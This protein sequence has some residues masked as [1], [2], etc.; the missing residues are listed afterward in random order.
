MKF[1][2]D[3]SMASVESIDDPDNMGILT[4]TIDKLGQETHPVYYTS[5]FATNSEGGFVAIPKVG[6]RI[7]TCSPYGTTDWYYLGSTFSPEPDEAV[8]DKVLDGYISPYERANPDATRARG[9]SQQSIIKGERGGGLKISEQYN[10]EMFNM[11]TRLE[12]T[13]GKKV[14]IND[15]PQTDAI[16]IGTEN[17]SSIKVFDN[18]QNPVNAPRSVEITT[19]GPQKYI[20]Q[21]D[22][23]DIVVYKGG[24]DL[25]LL[26]C[27]NASGWG[28]PVSTGNVNIQSKQKDINIF[29]K[30]GAGKIF[31]QCLDASGQSQHIQ[32]ETKGPDGTIAIKT[33]GNISIEAGGDINMNAGGQIN[34]RSGGQFSV[35]SA[36]DIQT[37]TPGTFTAEA[38]FVRLAEPASIPAGPQ[39][40]SKESSFGNNGVTK[41]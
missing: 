22:E 25:N 12:G 18:P 24:R 28:G 33:N 40:Q 1:L 8:G 35:D 27:A 14:E 38:G 11:Y 5:P 15:N 32:I 6:V 29:S 19:V 26:N 21:E 9:V 13:V 30:A 41:Y 37:R 23:T 7:L 39:S 34:M 20:N 2:M 31:I 4:C 16:I 3:I 17:N 36:A 10:P